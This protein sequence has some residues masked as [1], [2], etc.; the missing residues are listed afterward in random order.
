[1]TRLL[2]AIILP[3]FAL[4][5]SGVSFSQNPDPR[6]DP[7]VVQIVQLDHAD[8]EELARVLQPFLSKSGGITAYAPSNILIIRDRKSIVAEL[9]KAIKGRLTNGD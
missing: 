9:V 1:M 8:A 5:V 2:I 7:I 3:I 4:T 6:G